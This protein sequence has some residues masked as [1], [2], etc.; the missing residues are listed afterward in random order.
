M[1]L[2]AFI[3]FVW[4]NSVEVDLYQVQIPHRQVPLGFFL[5]NNGTQLSL[6]Y[7]TDIS[8][9]PIPQLFLA[10]LSPTNYGR[11]TPNDVALTDAATFFTT[12][13]SIDGLD[14]IYVYGDTSVHIPRTECLFT[15]GMTQ[16]TSSETFIMKFTSSGNLLWCKILG[17]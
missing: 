9:S 3:T 8:T 6:I 12:M 16:I 5:T 1:L 2:L 14:N 13:S 10:T 15:N 7:S 4:A 11:I 17:T